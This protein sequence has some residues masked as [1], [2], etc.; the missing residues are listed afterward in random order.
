MSADTGVPDSELEGVS[1]P[2]DINQKRRINLIN[3]LRERFHEQY[4]KI[5][6][7]L[8]SGQINEQLARKMLRQAVKQYALESEQ[9]IRA[10][11]PD[12]SS[13]PRAWAREEEAA[14]HTWKECELGA[15]EMRTQKVEFGGVEDFVEAPRTFTDTW[16]E[17]ANNPVSGADE[18]V[19]QEQHE[20]PLE[21]SERAYRALNYFW[22]EFGLDVKIDE[23]LP[24]DKI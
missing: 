6:D 2:S 24:H 14:Y 17:S 18:T 19:N 16:R 8:V 11:L 22:F 7:N 13:D 20:I 21:V 10:N 1:D 4:D 3:N 5:Y 23:K 9:V 15:L 12:T